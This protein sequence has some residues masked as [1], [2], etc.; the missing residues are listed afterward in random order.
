MRAP[1]PP[2]L[3]LHLYCHPTQPLFHPSPPEP[4]LTSEEVDEVRSRW[5]NEVDEEVDEGEERGN[6][7]EDAGGKG[8][9]VEEG[10]KRSSLPPPPL[11]A[12]PHLL[13]LHIPPLI[14]L[15]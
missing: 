3:L 4:P 13:L 6:E 14:L 5:N 9:E 2:L 15:H 11:P 12:T 1:P 8:D 10:M 7:V